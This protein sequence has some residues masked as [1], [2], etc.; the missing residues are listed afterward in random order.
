MRLAAILALEPRLLHSHLSK[1][2]SG[3][4]QRLI[5]DEAK[6]LPAGTAQ[7]VPPTDQNWGAVVRG[8]RTRGTLVDDPK[9]GTWSPGKG[10]EKI[11][12]D[13]WPDGRARFVLDVVRAAGGDTVTRSL[14]TEVKRWLDAEAA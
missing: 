3:E 11:D 12:T 4:W 14:P 9:A 5:G 6:P 7:F 13:G 2:Q 1:A 10:L 8:L